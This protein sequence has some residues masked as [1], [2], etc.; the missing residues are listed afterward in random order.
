MTSHAVSALPLPI[1]HQ[2]TS[3]P[4]SIPHLNENPTSTVHVVN[5]VFPSPPKAIH[6]EG[7][8]YLVPRPPS[9]Y[10]DP[11]TTSAPGILGTVFDSCSL[12]A[13]DL[14]HTNDYY[15]KAS[16]TKLTVMTGGPYPTLPLPPHLSSSELFADPGPIP[17]YIRSLIDTLQIQLGRELPEPIY[18][19]IWN[20]ED[21]IPTLTPGHL[22]RMQEM[23][24]V[25]TGGGW[26]RKLAVVGAGVGDVSVGDCV[27]A[28]RRVGRDW[29]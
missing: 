25:L 28:G 23:K 13:Q 27:E 17:P 3:K 6:P 21:C 10:P 22:D 7:F 1:L 24:K 12:H 4:D 20:N 9:G 2:L 14:P 18:W 26:G 5:L 16:H 19:R 29:V 15:N 8:G 11:S